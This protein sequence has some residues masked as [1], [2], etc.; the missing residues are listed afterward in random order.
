MWLAFQNN[1][2][3]PLS[4]AIMDYDTD[5]C[6]GEGGDWAT[7]GWWNLNPGESQTVLWTTNQYAYFY[8]EAVDGTWWGDSNGPGVYVHPEQFDSCYNIGATGDWYIINMAQAD[9][10]WPPVAPF[11]HTVNLNP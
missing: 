9:V 1:Y 2:S 5:A 10:G 6:G 8:A 7:H 3:Q 11:T 4:V